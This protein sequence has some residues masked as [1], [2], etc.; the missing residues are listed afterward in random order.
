MTDCWQP[1]RRTKRGSAGQSAARWGLAARL[2]GGGLQADRCE[3]LGVGVH[4]RCPSLKG[5][6]LQGQGGAQ[7]LRE[8]ELVYGVL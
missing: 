8:V 7:G 4:G 1:L 3:R 5:Q 6:G 2:G